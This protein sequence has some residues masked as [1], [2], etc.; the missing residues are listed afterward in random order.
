MRAQNLAVVERARDV[1][2][3]GVCHSL[4]HRPACAREVL[5]LHGAKPGHDIRRRLQCGIA[6]PLTGKTLGEQARGAHPF[7]RT[8]VR[9]YETVHVLPPSVD[10]CPSCRT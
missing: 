1:C 9:S 5:R 6:Q 7:F 4:S 8:Y 2:V 10:V 3:G